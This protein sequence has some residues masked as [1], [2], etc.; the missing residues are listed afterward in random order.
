MNNV[1]TRMAPSPTGKFHVGSART[2]L[3]SYLFGKHHGGKFILRIED[4]DK[5]RSK[6]EFETNIIESFEWLGLKY[7]EF[8]RQS[9]RTE[10]YKEQLKKLIDS[11][12]AYVS[13]A[14]EEEAIAEKNK[15]PN[16]KAST[17]G[18]RSSVIRFKNP[19]TKIKFQD[20]ILGE[21]EI[22]STDLGDFVIAKD[23]ETPLFHLTVVID[24]GLMGISHVIRAQEHLANTPRQILILEALGFARPIYAHIPLVLA[25]DKTKL[26]KRHGATALLDFRDMGYLPEAVLNFL[27]FLG[28]NPGTEQ[29]MFTLDEL[30]K[31]FSLEKVQKS[32][33]VFNMDK[34]NWFN[35]EYIKKMPQDLLI[36]EI[37]KF[38]DWPKDMIVRAKDAL[39]E[40]I[41]KF[42]D[43]Q[44]EVE[45]GFY[46]NLPD[47][48]ADSLIWKKSDK[49]KTL[50]HLEKMKEMLSNADF[51][52]IDSIKASVWD[53]VEANGKGDVLWPTRFALSG[54]EKSPDPF[55]L[56]Y[57]F[58]KEETLR[59]IQV[60]T[61]KLK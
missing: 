50:V 15:L 1:T 23:L 14:E 27:A 31:E 32:G 33:G 39:I 55:A 19:N 34:L 12:A 28:W 58:G 25:P 53:Y 38:L 22:D 2:A 26:S 48:S 6:P 4:T 21:I 43:L 7:D 57:I 20:V 54:K 59:R 11:G 60:A 18:K 47:Y 24:D 30:I 42:S 49:E 36:S 37:Q 16:A 61:E 51:S 41:N 3:F 35:K 46:K 8:Y 52:S 5:E 9:E 17:E 40:R 13:S 44:D 56:A 10:I 45:F 29:E